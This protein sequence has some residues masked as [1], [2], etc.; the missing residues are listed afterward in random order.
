MY[1]T[2]PR[3]TC[4]LMGDSWRWWRRW[5][6]CEVTDQLAQIVTA[7]G[8]LAVGVQPKYDVACVRDWFITPVSP[9]QIVVVS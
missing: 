3:F 2:I 6:S 4:E 8:Q 1:S 7:R 5:P 9:D